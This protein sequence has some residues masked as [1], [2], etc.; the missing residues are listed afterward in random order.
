MPASRCRQVPAA[1]ADKV[2][3]N[4]DRS[5]CICRTKGKPVQIHHIDKNRSDNKPDNLAVVC[6][7]CHSEIT[8][9]SGL[10]RSYTPGLVRKYK[11][12]WEKQVQ[13][14]RG[15]HKPRIRYKKELIT[16]IDLIV[17]EILACRPN[18]PR[19]EELVD[20]LY[21]LHLWRGSREIDKK[22][23]DGLWHLAIQSGISSPR[24]ASLVAEKLWQMCWHFVGPEYVP[25]GKHRL[26]HVLESVDALETL[27]MF[28]C[29]FGHGRKAVDTIVESAENFFEIGLWYSEK[30]IV[31]AAIRVYK[32]ALEA[33][34]SNKDRKIEF[35]YGRRVLRRSV[36]TLQKLLEEEQAGWSYQRR[37]LQQLLTL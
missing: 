1:V 30:R 17:C 10:G 23:L 29:G 20:L 15:I 28:N 19:I 16:Q 36:R 31:N 35:T 12:A 18:N 25:I 2:L 13:D 32:E 9:T 11:R 24:V 8:G 3:F 5:C 14:S 6:L 7:D 37:R 27:A 33:C 21:Q 22:I 26:A 34:H 4:A